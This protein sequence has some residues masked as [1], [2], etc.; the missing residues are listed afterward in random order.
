MVSNCRKSLF[1]KLGSCIVFVAA[2]MAMTS[3]RALDSI[4]KNGH[5]FTMDSKRSWAQAI[6]VESGVIVAV[7]PD[8]EVLKLA[9]K[10]TAV[11][12]LAGQTMLP[13]F[14][15]LHVHPLFAGISHFRCVVQEGADLQSALNSIEKCAK[16]KTQGQWITG[17]QWDVPALGVVPHR[18]MLDKIVPDIPIMLRDTSG[19]SAW[20]NSKALQLAGIG[21]APIELEG[22][23]VERDPNGQPTGILREEA[24]DLV[25]KIIP[26]PDAETIDKAMLW[27]LDQM[28]GYGITSL[29]EAS[30][31]F[32][33]GPYAELEAYARLADEDK[34]K[35]RARICTT[36]MPQ[37]EE[38]ELAI[39]M[40]N[41]FARDRVRTDCIK[42]H[43]DG[44]P[45]DSHTAAMLEPYSG[46][47]EG[48]QDEASK[49]GLL[50]LEKEMVNQAVTR[51]DRMGLTV[52][53]HAAGDAAVRTGLRAIGAARKANGYTGVMHDVGHCTFVA[54]DDMAYGAQI[55]ATF[56][57]SPYLWSPSPINESISN[58]IGDKRIERVWP[59]RELVDSGALV[60]PGSDWSVV[61]SANPWVAIES[62]V[63]RERPGGSD[64]SFGKKQAIGLI[65]ALELFTVNSA[66]HSGR[67]HQLGSIEVGMLADLVVVDK[68][69][70]EI[71]VNKLHRVH[72]T[73]T[74]IN[75]QRVYVR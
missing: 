46:Q 52:K 4:Y 51:F 66:R 11:I 42:I 14:H 8:R 20:V 28:L 69:P 22:G 38:I 65:E 40:R 50:L 49:K 23:I 74:I 41:Q 1:F 58:A 68:N 75:G 60:V 71:P 12:D 53:F 33:A 16:N 26:K 45:T 9:T 3:A 72:V 57:V 18:R 47:V 24:I 73:Q 55:G 27:A 44:V 2:A 21:T 5:I 54:K 63:T 36:W 17:R 43:L 15:D 39:S 59:V 62:L 25:E 64:D 56:E 35:Q 7:G 67:S 29:T 48:R 19:H 70:F 6:A 13:G 32:V 34:L 30:G 37:S 10:E 61:P 31:G